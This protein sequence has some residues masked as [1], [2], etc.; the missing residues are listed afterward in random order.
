VNTTTNPNKRRVKTVLIRRHTHETRYT[1]TMAN[2]IS[3]PVSNQPNA[4]KSLFLGWI[5]YQ[6]RA[7]H[8]L[9]RRE[10][11]GH[12]AAGGLHYLCTA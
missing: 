7:N 3:A 6:N 4:I 9:F 1:Y 10:K 5:S 11:V 2:G 12:I 8:L